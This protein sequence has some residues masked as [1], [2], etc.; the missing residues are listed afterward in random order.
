MTS[1]FT[2]LALFLAIIASFVTLYYMCDTGRIG[3]C[4][5]KKDKED[6][7]NLNESGMA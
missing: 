2:I 7:Q 5:S 3:C 1:F 6:K 4:K